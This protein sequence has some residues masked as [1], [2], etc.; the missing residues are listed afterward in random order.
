MATVDDGSNANL[1]SSVW[2]FC[3]LHTKHQMAKTNKKF[4]IMLTRCTKV[5]A[6]PVCKLS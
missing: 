3:I 6:V 4:K 5:I 2:Q 1:K